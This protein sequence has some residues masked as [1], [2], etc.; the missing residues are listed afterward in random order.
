MAYSIDLRIKVIEA[1]EGNQINSQ[2]ELSEIFG[3]SLSTLKRWLRRKKA[4]DDLSPKIEGKGRPAKID[5][6]GLT[7]ISLLVAK[8]PDITLREL[9]EA[10]YKKHQVQVSSSILFRALKHLNITHKKIS[11]NAS[12]QSEDEV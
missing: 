7:T 10:Y 1:H 5:E 3:I 6:R 2:N 8:D 12:E 9:S 11:I 4:G